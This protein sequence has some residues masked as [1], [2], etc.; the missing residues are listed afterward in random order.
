MNIT[1][2]KVSQDKTSLELALTSAA[3]A[4][5]LH[6]WTNKTYRVDELKIDLSAKLTGAT[7]PVI[8]ITPQDLGITSFDGVYFI[9]LTDNVETLTAVTAELSKYKECV[10]EKVLAIKDCDSCMEIENP[11][12]LNVQTAL[13]TLE[14][15]LS[16]KAY[17]E[18]LTIVFMLD[19]FCTNDCRGCGDYKIT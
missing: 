18:I 16:E 7:N 6:L 14:L 9:E 12:V 5:T 17:Q 8:Y 13:Y 1:S 19:K 15:A 2:F 3:A 11:E 10:I 4:T